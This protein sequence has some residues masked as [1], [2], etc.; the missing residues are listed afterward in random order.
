MATLVS[1]GLD[2]PFDVAVDASGNVYIA[3]AFNNAI[4][5]WNAST[6]Q[7][8][9]LVSS[10]LN[11]P[12]SVAVDAAGNVYIA[13]FENNAIKEWN[14]STQ[15]VSTLVSSGLNFAQGVAVDA[16]GNVYI[17]DTDNNAIKEWN[18]TTQQVSTL[19]SGLSLPDGI[20]V[21]AAGNVYIADSGDNAIKEWHAATGQLST[22]V[23]S[24]LMSP[25]G[26]AVDGAGNVYIADTNHGAI[27]EWYAATGQ[28]ASLASGLN[29]PFGAAVDGAGNLYVAEGNISTI[30][31]RVNAYVPG[32][33]YEVSAAGSDTLA[34]LP[35]TTS[36]TGIFAPSSDQSWL[37]LGTPAAGVIPFSF[38]VNT[39]AARTAHIALFGQQVTVTQA[40]P[41]TVTASPATLS[42]GAATLTINGSGF[43]PDIA[44]DVVN[45][46]G[47]GA[48]QVIAATPTQLTIGD[49]SG[50]EP[51]IL[52]ATVSVKG[53]SAGSAVQVATVI[54]T[55]TYTA[56]RAGVIYASIPYQVTA[57]IPLPTYTAGSILEINAATGQETPLWQGTPN[58]AEGPSNGNLA[59]ASNGTIYFVGTVAGQSGVFSINPQ[60]ANPTPTLVDADNRITSLAFAPDGTLY[61]TIPWFL[62]IN[63]MPGAILTIDPATGQEATI[64]AGPAGTLQGPESAGL[65]IRND[66][67]IFFA[68]SAGGQQGVF[69]LNPTAAAPTPTLLDA[70]SSVTSLVFAPDGTLYA[71]IPPFFL[72]AP[73]PGY[74][75]GSVLKIDQTTG[76]ETPIWQGTP[77]TNEGP[78]AFGLSV[79]NTGTLVFPAIVGGTA[80][81]YT[82]D[83]TAANPTPTLLDGDGSVLGVAVP[84]SAPSTPSTYTLR[85]DGTGANVQIVNGANVLASAPLADT[86]S[87]S[88]AGHAAGGDVLTL[89]YSNGD[90]L[91]NGTSGI[92]LNFNGG[93]ANQATLDVTGPVN[94]VTYDASSAHA[95]ALDI[96]DANGHTGTVNFTGLAP[97]NLDSAASVVTVN[98]TDST[99]SHTA[100][101]T[102]GPAGQNTVSFNGGLESLT[103]NDPTSALNVNGASA[104]DTF[105]FNSLDSGFNANLVVTGNS[106]S[107][108]TNLD[109]P[110]LVVSSA[111]AS[112]NVIVSTNTINLGGNI[113]ATGAGTNSGAILLTGNVA[114]T[115]NAT[116][117]YS[118]VNSLQLSG[119]VNLGAHTLTVSDD[120]ATDVGSI[121]G[122]ISGVNGALTKTGPGTLKLLG[123]GSSYSGT[124]TIQNGTLQIGDGGATGSLGSGA[125]TDDSTLFFDLS[126]NIN[127]TNAISGSGTL[128]LT[129]SAGAI[130][131]STAITVATLAA[132]ASTG[133]T[134]TNTGNIVSSFSATDTT[135]GDIS[136][137]DSGA[138]SVTG[139]TQSGSGNVNVS[140]AGSLTVAAN[141]VIASGAG[142]ISLAADVNAD[143]SGNSNTA[144]LAIES[145]A[146][147]VSAS[148]I[149]LRGYDIAIAASITPVVQ[150]GAVVIRSSLAGDPM[151][152]GGG[153]NVAGINLTDAELVELSTTATGS[154]TFGD[155]EQTGT[156]TFHGTTPTTPGASMVAVQ[157]ATGPGQIVLDDSNGPALS[158]NDSNGA[159]GGTI[160]LAAGTGGIVA[161]NPNDAV[162]EIATTG[163][164]F[165][166]TAGAVGSPSNRIQ[167]DGVNT[168]SSVVVG[169][170]AEPSA[171]YLDGLGNLTLGNVVGVT[172]NTNL[173]VTARGALAVA[174]NAVIDSGTGIISLAADVN[175]D[176]SA[177]S[178]T[179]NLAIQSG[180]VVDSANPG[181]NAITLRGY[182]VTIATGSTP[183]L[184]GGHYQLVAAPANTLTGIYDIYDVAIDA[185]GDR[186]VTESLPNQVAEFAPASTTPT[187]FLTGVSNPTWL[188]FAPN[189]NLYVISAFS[190]SGAVYTP[191][192][193]TPSASLSGLSSPQAL[194]FDS[195][196]NLFVVNE[197][198]NTVTEYAPGSTSPTATLTGLS[199][200][201]ALALDPAGNL[202]V[203]NSGNNT[204]SEFAPGSTT[205]TATLA[206]S[207]P[208]RLAL[209]QAGDL[210]VLNNSAGTASEFA[211]GSAT[212]TAVISG[213][214]HP[215]ALLF[216]AAGDLLISNAG[217]NTLREFA[218]GGSTPFATLAGLNET[219]NMAFDASG[220]L[221]VVNYASASVGEFV[222]TPVI[223]AGGVVIRSSLASD[224][225]SIGGGNSDVA[226]INLTDAELAQIQTSAAGSITFGDSTQTGNI[227]FKTTTPATTAGASVVALQATSGGGAIVL[228]DQASGVA[229]NGNSGN[230]SLTAGTGGIVAASANNAFA[231]LAT[232]AQVSLNTIGNIGSASNRIQFDA[233][234]VP[235]SV[236]IGGADQPGAVYLD[237]LGSLTLG[238]VTGSSANTNLDA[239]ARNAL[240]IVANATI[241]TGLGT[242]SLAAD[243]NADGTGNANTGN[244]AIQS[245]AIVVSANPSP[246]AIT[247]GGYDIDI[248]TS[249]HPAVV[250]ARRT[251]SSTVSGFV[252][253][254]VT[255]P[256]GLAFDSNGDL[257][258][259]NSGIVSE[260]AAGSSTATPFITSGLFNPLGLAFDASG[261]LFISNYTS[262]IVSEVVAGTSTAIPF[263]TSGLSHPTSLAFD[264]SGDLFIANSGNNT[265]S[266]V[267]AGST[268][269]LP[270]ITSGLSVPYG[271]AFDASGDLFIGNDQSS[272]VSEVV[273]GSSTATPFISGLSNPDGLAFDAKGDLFIAN[274]GNSTVSEVAAGTSTATPFI[275]SGLNES[276]ALAFD[277]NGN[278]FISNVN[279][280][281][282]S[283]AALVL[284]PVAGGVAIRS[285]L[286]GDPMSIGSNSDVSGINLTDA[287][288]AQIK[289]TAAGSITFG[290]SSQTGNITF[291][292]ATTAT[293]A[294]ASIVVLQ[295]TSGAGTIVLDD[296]NS[297]P[298]LNGNGG[299]VSLTAGTGGIVAQRAS[300][301]FAEIATTGVVTL[302]TTGIIGS[303]ANPIQFDATATPAG[304]VIGSTNQP[305]AVYLAGLGSLT[306]TSVSAASTDADVNVTAVSITVNGA[307]SVGSGDVT[308][309]AADGV[310]IATTGSVTTTG[311]FSVNA[312]S[313][314]DGNGTY[315]QDGAVSAAG[316]DIVAANINLLG[317]LAATS[318]AS[319]LNASTPGAT[320]GIGS[321]GSFTLSNA[322]LN[323][324]SVP[325]LDDL[326]IGDSSNTG[327]ITIA[328]SED[329]SVTMRIQFQTGGNIAI[330]VHNYIASSWVTLSAGGAITDA[331]GHV[332]APTMNLSAVSGISL[333]TA[334]GALS[335]SNSTSGN[336]SITQT[337]NVDIVGLVNSALGGLV[338][339][340]T[341]AGSI[342]TSVPVAAAGAGNVILTA[343]GASSSITLNAGI[344]TGAGNIQLTAGDGIA[345]MGAAV[346]TTGTY[347]ANAD[348][349]ADGVGAYSSDAASPV[350]VGAA[351][352]TAGS[353]NLLGTTTATTGSLTVTAGVVTAIGADITANHNIILQPELATTTVGVNDP[354]GT[355]DLSDAE[356][357]YLFAPGTLTIGAAGGTGA[358]GIGG[359]GVVDLSGKNFGLTL[360]GG[361]T[362]F[363]GGLILASNKTLTLNTGAI[364]NKAATAV[365][366]G[367]SQGAIVLG[368]TGTVGS[369]ARPLTTQVAQLVGPGS[370][371][372]TLFFSDAVGL[373]TTGTTTVS[374]P[375][376]LFLASDFTSHLGDLAASRR[377]SHAQRRRRAEPRR[378]RASVEQRDAQR[379]RHAPACRA[380]LDRERQLDQQ[381]HRRPVRHERPARDRGR[382]D[383]VQRRHLCL[384]R[385]RHR[386]LQ[387][388]SVPRGGLLQRLGRHRQRPRRHACR[389]LHPGGADQHAQ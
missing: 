74:Q 86:T 313:D 262:S 93:T 371:T 58:T 230:I 23:A 114:L 107:D 76:L 30:E 119:P 215:N 320:I 250:G 7:V 95:G 150:A 257:F 306:L 279:S 140:S 25:Q 182:N 44:N 120:L 41:P 377:H 80:G 27:K 173:D 281:T 265:V 207:N 47:N 325:S 378:R 121:A 72:I 224:P 388:R 18:A 341:T 8:S 133:I 274:F 295:S 129:S 165:L 343:G 347:S 134:L 21:D 348:S 285:S 106:G 17:A 322:E 68:G 64:W 169:I 373:T 37:A 175:A 309:T 42:T 244:L 176:G 14:A 321:A 116:L 118:G 209:D 280:N 24:G 312:D 29:G 235:S 91:F 308:L 104:A 363:D 78:D 189:G 163:Q 131:Q 66:G 31:E 316:F 161:A 260:V 10:G 20:A 195:Y 352:I 300:N 380:R 261:D 138:L 187:A 236:V 149:T 188:A 335:A 196:G 367:G 302:N 247:L 71:S 61:G 358:V 43:D 49:L 330:G 192:S 55:F 228:D 199:Q 38:S 142:A 284:N 249:A 153:N 331:G 226:G 372:G 87:I 39:G 89:D 159:T 157:A 186:F 338:S 319:T 148:T 336:I 125:V 16:A 359:Q 355:L 291:K 245:G 92:T 112:H 296:Q 339:L 136:L 240:T 5:E 351:S 52:D 46:G 206:V 26:V 304:V 94:A 364:V 180:A 160:T 113:D 294:G 251:L 218:P 362:T 174:P 183:A 152:I 103:F 211:P 263:V 346:T 181:S 233:T 28:V 382:R 345:L 166:N 127:V 299:A 124:T 271:L 344:S 386:Q 334:A 283:K 171:V 75:A 246:S 248:D 193:T 40:G 115:A 100:T 340:I 241:D 268:T 59:I 1:T 164:V 216:D 53:V 238:N 90:P 305:S 223:D 368:P 2:A 332:T 317:S 98:I 298:A 266:E 144:N 69:T 67:T 34:V 99:V 227:T 70:D 270:F 333:N 356:L 277:A 292:T 288:L 324:I 122:A 310:T 83:P 51:G 32:P 374:G 84:P 15:Q 88:I 123:A 200:P 168:P 315:T 273:A 96:T 258:I 311:E 327:G 210:F 297:G 264:S 282:V 147:V 269:A 234:H 156:I 205:P 36:L 137:A 276:I 375:I 220:D 139:I 222:A 318:L 353:V 219:L 243:A 202:W 178:N 337:G 301:A 349:N 145:G 170:S 105:T 73:T 379:R 252:T 213:L 13:D 197:G 85:L 354:S 384:R 286:A 365:T 217:D 109:I 370:V 184:V 167:L 185:A 242:I 101:F 198:N 231:E 385:H 275:T 54:G 6:Q 383:H 111:L 369:L 237:G 65:A 278:L 328:G 154:I 77:N 259:V 82:L 11:H 141:A 190:S 35:T 9:T 45:F 155:S 254:G 151:S 117:T 360:R 376:Y 19:V 323:L 135:S 203:S 253:S 81:V 97:V 214:N 255:N 194:L 293:T 329:V 289:T 50:L 256:G 48:G 132:S 110:N 307:V 357:A 22:V 229:L 272:T 342:I 287:E 314:A 79:Q 221:Y 212:P 128:D 303:A 267:A 191:G 350:T 126:G 232:T 102:A 326:Y 33:V 204:T 56:D 225:M 146:G 366:I 108:I 63:P 239:T 130:T 361:T 172:A 208:G 143:G 290:D 60:A 62:S 4:K 162:A 57:T 158:G 3:D 389:R 381:R 387:R 177:D 179:G 201:T 12:E